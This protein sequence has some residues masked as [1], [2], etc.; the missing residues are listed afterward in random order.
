MDLAALKKETKNILELRKRPT[1]E[2]IFAHTK[3]MAVNLYEDILAMFK[4]SNDDTNK[5]ILY[6]SSPV[7]SITEVHLY[8][9][10]ETDIKCT[11]V[12]NNSIEGKRSFDIED[13]LIKKYFPNLYKAGTKITKGLFSKDVWRAIRQL[14]KEEFKEYFEV[15]LDNE[16]RLKVSAK[17]L[18]KN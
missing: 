6:T 17:P 16:Y 10:N 3:E 2:E 15:S 7:E 11:V 12:F 14:I 13:D 8:T 9:I 18:I 1:N 5:K 4:A